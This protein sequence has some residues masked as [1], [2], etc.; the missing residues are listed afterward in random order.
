MEKEGRWNFAYV[1]PKLNKS[2]STHI[3]VPNSIQMGWVESMYVFCAGSETA[4]DTAQKLLQSKK[5]PPHPLEHHVLLDKI[6]EPKDLSLKNHIS[7]EKLL[8]LIEV[9]V[10]D[11]IAAYQEKPSKSFGTQP[12]VC[13]MESI[14]FFRTEFRSK[15]C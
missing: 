13:C 3:V 9:Y 8:T 2:D 14:A 4:R 1:L 6:E 5:L 11:S 7:P 12:G 15:N 10:D